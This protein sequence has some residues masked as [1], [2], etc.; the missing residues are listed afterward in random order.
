MDFD[1]DFSPK[2]T[3]LLSLS[4]ETMDSEPNTRLEIFQDHLRDPFLLC[5]LGKT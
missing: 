1:K 5:G 4:P 3:F 2:P